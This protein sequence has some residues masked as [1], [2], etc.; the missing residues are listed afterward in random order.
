MLA[1]TEACR[2]VEL[3]NFTGASD[4]VQFEAY[5]VDDGEPISDD[6]MQYISERYAA[7]IDEEWHDRQI[8]RAEFYAE[9]AEDR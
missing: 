1:K 3:Q 6:D 4:D 2:E 9:L 5:Y 8:A 7:E